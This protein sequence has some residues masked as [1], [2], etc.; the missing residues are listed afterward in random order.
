V[1]QILKKIA[2]NMRYYRLKKKLT[3]KQLAKKAKLSRGFVNRIE[4]AK[5]NI[6]LTTLYAIA[7]ALDV[8]ARELV[9]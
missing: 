4:N 2:N 6:Y 5:V 7:K 1:S 3:Q 8:S 9:K